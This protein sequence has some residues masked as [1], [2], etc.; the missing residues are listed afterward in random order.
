VRELQAQLQ[1]AFDEIRIE[2][3]EIRAASDT[4]VVVLGRLRVRGRASGAV[5]SS[6][7][8]WVF[9]LRAGKVVRQETFAEQNEGMKAAGLGN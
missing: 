3:D 2:A 4:V 6:T 7:R 8:A 9:T 5:G 1:E